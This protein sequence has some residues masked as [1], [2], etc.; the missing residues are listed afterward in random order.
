MTKIV[1]DNVAVEFPI[2]GLG[3]LS[4]RKNLLHLTTAGKLAK[5]AHNIPIVRAL[6]D[7]NFIIE[8]GQR[9]GLSGHNGSGKSTMLRLLA[10]IYAP[11]RGNITV[12]GKIASILDI[13]LGMD[14]EATGYENI[15]LRGVLLGESVA[16]MRRRTPEIK[17]LS[18]LDN[19]LELPVRTYS[20]GMR[21]RLGFAISMTMDADIFLLD[22]WLAVG[23]AQFR[24]KA[25]AHL[26]SVVDNAAVVV[27]ASHDETLLK[28]VCNRIIRLENGFIVEDKAN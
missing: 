8:P 21:V 2:Y 18:G 26:K 13:F 20:T 11:T 24:E 7:I 15:L 27:I 1:L 22:E 9:V 12:N 19:Y 3:N 28:S 5:D 14:E 10:G 4:W 6:T 23:D 16:S 17:E 25:E